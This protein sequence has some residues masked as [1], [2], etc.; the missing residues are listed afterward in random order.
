MV[1]VVQFGEGGFLRA[2]ADYMIDIANEK[3]VFS[4]KVAI[5]KPI[6]FGTLE[7]FAKQ[8]CKYNVV[9]RGIVD[10][11]VSETTRK[12]NCIETAVDPYT[13]YDEYIYRTGFGNDRLKSRGRPD[14]GNRSGESCGG[15]ARRGV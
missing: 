5:V 6:P 13:Q 9:L 12:I 2:F 3:G 11:K 4:G 7:K 14:S 1:K 10:G 8:D 15:R